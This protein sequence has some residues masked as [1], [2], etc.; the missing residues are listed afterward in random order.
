LLG[1]VRGVVW[2]AVAFAAVRLLA[3]LAS[4]WHEF[5]DSLRPDFTLWKSQLA[6]ALPFALAVG[7]E[8][9]QANFHQYV[10]ASRFDAA[11]FAIFA[12]GC[13]QIPLVDVIASSSAN[14][15]MVRMAENGFDS[16][17]QEALALWHRTIARLAA[18]IFPLT[19]FLLITARDIIA[20]LFTES[21]V[22]SVPIFMVS[23][24][25]IL[26]SVFCIDAVLRVHA[27]TRFLFGM[28]LLRLAVVAGFIGWFLSMFGLVGAVLITVTATAL[29]RVI[30]LARIARLM[31]VGIADV[32]PWRRLALSAAFALAAAFPAVWI[33]R[34]L[35]LPAFLELVCAAATYGA[36]YITLRLAEDA[37][38]KPRAYVGETSATTAS[39]PLN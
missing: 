6:Y 7:I 27:Q 18:V 39:T 38:H 37:L 33:A 30:G 8:V 28:N 5:K 2:G 29:V 21:Y 19:V 24:L 35:A 10:V 16:R 26:L 31:N 32:L 14:V 9:V 17:G 20:I 34:A 13:L 4:F 3:M 15:M 25:T 12:V 1:G 11:A 23:T 36:T 22:A